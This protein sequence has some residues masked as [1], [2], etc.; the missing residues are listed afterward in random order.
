MLNIKA[1]ADDNLRVLKMHIRKKSKT[2]NNFTDDSSSIALK[3]EQLEA[4]IDEYLHFYND[5]VYNYN[6][7]LARFPNNIA[8]KIL[9]LRK[10]SLFQVDNTHSDDIE[11]SSEKS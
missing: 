10:L 11:A 3:L 6:K 9:G 7:L 2:I 8:G 4:R 5:N 1:L